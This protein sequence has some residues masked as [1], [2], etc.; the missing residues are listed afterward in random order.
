MEQFINFCIE[1]NITIST[2]ESFTGGFL[3]HEITNISNSSKIF[4][5]GFVC[6]S[7]EFKINILN[8]PQKVIKKYSSVSEECLTEMLNN[9]QILLK[10]DL[11]LGFTGFAPPLDETNPK[12][13]LVFYGIKYK[14]E[15][16]IF[17]FTTKTN[18]LRE[19]FKKEVKEKVLKK[20]HIILN[21]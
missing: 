6:Y 8:V 21:F 3:A 15:I 19:D 9:T 14:D 13:G 7:D 18:S 2:C 10:T 4:K 17:S 11:V 1:K 5:G 12:S 20:V 16:N